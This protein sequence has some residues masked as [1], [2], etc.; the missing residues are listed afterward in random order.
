MKFL[1]RILTKILFWLDGVPVNVLQKIFNVLNVFKRV[2][3]LQTLDIIVELSKTDKDD[4]ILIFLREHIVEF[5]R[6][7]NVSGTEFI[8]CQDVLLED[9]RIICYLNAIIKVSGKTIPEIFKELFLFIA[10]KK[11]INVLP[12]HLE[13]I[14]ETS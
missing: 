14:H 8:R 7:F 12:S 11:N 13:L 10:D 4:Q 3:E 9:K 1:K 6:L 5:S 2:V